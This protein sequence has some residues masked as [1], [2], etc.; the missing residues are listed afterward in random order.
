MAS[1][2]LTTSAP[3]RPALAPTV[4]HLQADRLVLEV[5]TLVVA[6]LLSLGL[7]WG[8]MY[9]TLRLGIPLLI[10]MLTAVT[11]FRM[12]V[13]D[14]SMLLTPLFGVRLCAM[15][16]FGIGGLF[17]FFAPDEVRM[18]Q[19][20]SYPTSSA[21]AAKVNLL[22]M[23][24]L[25][26]LMVGAFVAMR[27][28]RDRV[29][30]SDQ[31]LPSLSALPLDVGI[32]MFGLASGFEVFRLVVTSLFEVTLP[33]ILAN[34]GLAFQLFGLFLVGQHV[35]ESKKARIV[36]AV[37]L[38]GL[39]IFSLVV[40]A[41]TLFLYPALVTILGALSNKVTWRRTVLGA[42][43]LMF[44][45]VIM[46]PIVT[47]ARIRM[48]NEYGEM[49]N[50]PL[51]ARIN[52][53]MDYARGDRIQESD[54]GYSLSR[55]DYVMPASFVMAQYD[56]GM[57]SQ[58]LANSAFI[59]VPRI[60]WPDKPETSTSGREVNYA[61]GFHGINQIGT[62]IFADLYWA[63]GWYGLALLALFG[64]YVG[65]VSIMCE[66]ILRRGDWVLLPFTFASMRLGLNL[67]N[68]FTS[69]IMAPAVINLALF[70]GL[71]LAAHFLRRMPKF[72]DTY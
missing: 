26:V 13:A 39:F 27:L 2:H 64:V 8:E 66:S 35:G 12:I 19:D 34:L 58:R 5:I 72:R 44:G 67:D 63:I 61:L 14:S 56:Q 57:G 53:L 65:S 68:D 15:V 48:M 38:L 71:R 52:Y 24:G 37:A 69:G 43:L 11:N 28:H 7:Y 1:L 62:T 42:A 32:L 17:N 45:F 6:S 22:W 20:Y 70:A 51:E 59:F 4:A 25:T 36:V 30:A 50:P 49:T 18:G 31:Q 23:L 47:Y 46:S 54:V 16:V 41:K 9:E 60:I 40:T 3:Q 21:E 10:L 55:L 33:G 29:S